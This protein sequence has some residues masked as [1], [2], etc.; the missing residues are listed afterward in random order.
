M[1]KI[2][3]AIFEVFIY[4]IFIIM[5]NLTG[6][7]IINPIAKFIGNV[8]LISAINDS[9]TR[10]AVDSALIALV[11]NL[12]LLIVN[13]P[14]KI[15]GSLRTKNYTDAVIISLDS[16]KRQSKAELEL[17]VDYKFKLFK[18]A[19][20]KIGGT[21]L[22]IHNTDFTSMQIESR[23]SRLQRASTMLSS[24]EL[25][26]KLESSVQQRYCSGNSRLTFI[27]EPDVS[28]TERGKITTEI[29][30]LVDKNRKFA[31]TWAKFVCSILISKNIEDLEVNVIREND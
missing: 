22:I 29:R 23:S 6:L 16:R 11:V 8:N 31:Y 21:S 18:W 12:I 24:K 19:L 13:K 28:E 17:K 20:L 4:P 1:K 10:V 27:L 14:V 2:F 3:N 5:F 30:P 7:S 9:S 25:Q 15:S 26:I